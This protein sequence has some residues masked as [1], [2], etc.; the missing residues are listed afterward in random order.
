MPRASRQT[1]LDLLAVLAVVCMALSTTAL[2]RR[3]FFP[4]VR[5]RGEIAVPVKNWADYTATGHRIGDANASITVLEFADFQCPAC[6]VFATSVWPQLKR[7]YGDRIALVFRHWPLSYH[8]SAQP[9]AV[10]AVCSAAQGAFEAFHDLVYRQPDSLGKKPLDRFATEAGVTEISR[11]RTCL[12]D[13][14]IASLVDRDANAARSIG[15][16]GTPTIAINRVRYSRWSDTTWLFQTIDS[17]L[18]APRGR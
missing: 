15:G 2:V 17:L 8:A 3:E 18:A 11:F 6:R 1:V 16:T 10:A 5:K 9:T 7:R 4:K 14:S 12:N 13:K